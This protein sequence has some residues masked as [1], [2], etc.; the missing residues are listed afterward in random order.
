[1]TTLDAKVAFLHVIDDH[2]WLAAS[3]CMWNLVGPNGATG[4]KKE[5]D[6]LLPNC[7]VMARDCLLVHARSLIKFYRNSSRR[8]TDIILSDF[9]VPA[10]DVSLRDRLESFEYSIEV[11]LLHLTDW[12]DSDYRRLN[13]TSRDAKRD[14]VDWDRDA[15]SIVDL[16]FE[17][18]NHVSRHGGAWQRPFKDLLD[19]TSARYRDSSFAWPANLGEKAEVDHYLT[20][21]GL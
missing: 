6:R 7:D 12:R 5:A 4:A 10:V 11:H 19:A 20:A 9:R 8:I 13:A 14:R 17:A 1:V 18:L 21:L 2:R 16:I 15:T 3:G